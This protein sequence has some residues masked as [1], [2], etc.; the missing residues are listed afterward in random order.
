[1]NWDDIRLLYF[2]EIRCALRER[3]VMLYVV[4]VPALL[5]P[6]LV[7]LTMTSLSFVMGQS[8]RTALRITTG[9][10]PAACS[11]LV[12]ELKRDIKGAEVTSALFTTPPT[13]LEGADVLLNFQGESSCQV[14]FDSSRFRSISG[15]ERV[16]NFLRHYRDKKL[17]DKGHEFNLRTADMQLFGVVSQNLSSHQDVGRYLLGVLLPF[18]LIVILSLGGMYSAIDC[19]AGER[20]RSTWETSLTLASNRTNL[21]IAKY[22][23]VT[24][25]SST[26]G[27]FTLVALTFSLRSFVTPLL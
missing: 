7:W 16:E 10:L 21:V 13:S 2:H 25:M 20:E 24:T 18:T 17:E 9:A 8:E 26:A 19:T 15:K 11:D 5:Y 12:A 1:M 23:Y 4:L 22:L 3:N 27:M 6:L 14:L